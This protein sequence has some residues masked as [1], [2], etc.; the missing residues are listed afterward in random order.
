MQT[1][2]L[3]GTPCNALVVALLPYIGVVALGGSPYLAVHDWRL[4]AIAV[5]V[6]GSYAVFVIIGYLKDVVADRSTGYDTLPV[7]FGVRCSVLVSGGFALLG[8]VGSAAVVCHGLSV[9]P[10]RTPVVIGVLFWIVGLACLA[11][12]HGL[13]WRVTRDDEAHGAIAWS[14]RAF[15]ALHF[16]EALV[17]DPTLTPLAALLAVAFEFVL[18]LRP[19]RSQI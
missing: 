13:A 7:H 17:T 4:H 10:L 2:L 12:C 8:A 15:L 6:F 11:V 18:A 5:S 3:G 19:A 9:A 14:V 1:P 16:G